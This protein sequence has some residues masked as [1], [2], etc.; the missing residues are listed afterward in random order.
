MEAAGTFETLVS[1]HN[2]TWRHNSEDLAL[3]PCMMFILQFHVDQVIWYWPQH[4]DL[5]FI[6]DHCSLF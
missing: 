2:T 1:N 6:L 5:H 4:Y 3:N